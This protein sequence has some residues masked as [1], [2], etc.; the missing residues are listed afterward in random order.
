MKTFNEWLLDLNESITFQVADIKDDQKLEDLH[1]LCWKL[2]FKVYDMFKNDFQIVFKSSQI[3]PYD[4]ITPD[5]D[6]YSSGKEVINFYGGYFGESAGKILDAIKYL[7]L[8]FNMK[9][10]GT[11][12]QEMSTRNVMV[13]R[14]PV[15]VVANSNPAPE[16]NVANE[17]AREILNMLNISGD[18][19][20][21]IDVRELNMKLSTITDFH[22]GMMVR[23]PEVGS[24]FIHFGLG[25]HQIE[26]YVKVLQSIVDW[27]LKNNYDTISYC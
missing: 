22:K 8:E 12:K 5:G 20:G 9:L 23:A 16:L 2:S 13:Y 14:I 26:R 25:E 3:S 18:L 1:S 11:V 24:N 21:S 4:L 10:S 7:L 19:C 6:Y 27:A 17:N 15:V